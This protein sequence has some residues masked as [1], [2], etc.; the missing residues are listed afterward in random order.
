MNIDV[1]CSN[2]VD[3]PSRAPHS[4]KNP[5]FFPLKSWT[6]FP[7]WP[8]WPISW[9]SCPSPDPEIFE[10]LYALEE[11]GSKTLRAYEI[12]F[13]FSCEL[14]L[15][16][17]H[18]ARVLSTLAEFYTWNNQGSGPPNLVA[19][20]IPSISLFLPGP[21]P[22]TEWPPCRSGLFSPIDNFHWFLP[23]KTFEYYR[24]FAGAFHFSHHQHNP[25]IPFIAHWGWMYTLRFSYWTPFRS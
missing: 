22:R 15:Q 21:Q 1:E 2:R 14:F 6:T 19:T 11:G 8:Y 18:T 5:F 17:L 20:K 23:K 25:K 16:I 3:P 10:K 4:M 9:A 12:S 7:S 13:S 24:N